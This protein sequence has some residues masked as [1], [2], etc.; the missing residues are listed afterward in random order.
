M[1]QPDRERSHPDPDH[2]RLSLAFG[3]P[4]WAWLRDRLRRHLT[5]GRPIPQVCHLQNPDPSEW[6]AAA[7]LLGRPASRPGRTLR[8]PTADL[9]S[10]LV[11]AGLCSSL[12]EALET[13][14]GPIRS[15]LAVAGTMIKQRNPT[16]IR[17]TRNR[18]VR[19]VVLRID[20]R[21]D[22]FHK[23]VS[24][25]VSEVFMFVEWAHFNLF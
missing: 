7:A 2:A 9:E 12:R 19:R 17:P 6:D 18:H 14:D 25:Y 1:T 5:N 8:V 22:P 21:D 3:T 13:L 11:R 24:L 20:V 23:D 16:P 4:A 15:L 10:R